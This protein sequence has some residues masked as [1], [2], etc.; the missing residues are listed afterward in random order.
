MKPRSVLATR[1]GRIRQ[2]LG[3]AASQRATD[4]KVQGKKIISLAIGTRDFTV[5]DNVRR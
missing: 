3:N 2:S 5:A 4:L 1:T